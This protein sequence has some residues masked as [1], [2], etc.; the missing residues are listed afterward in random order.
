M[1]SADGPGGENQKREPRASSGP[2]PLF[3][4]LPAMFVVFVA[5]LVIGIAMPVL[6]LFVHQR[7]GLSTTVVGV[8]AGLEFVSALLTRV[9]SPT[10]A[11]SW[12]SA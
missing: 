8:V 4:L 6:P 1:T 9:W 12:D 3:V 10:R 2:A 5:F 11:W 7:L